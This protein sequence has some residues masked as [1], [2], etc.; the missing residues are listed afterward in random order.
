M[1][2]VVCAVLFF[3]CLARDDLWRLFW[4]VIL[5]GVVELSVGLVWFVG[6]CSFRSVVVACFGMSAFDQESAAL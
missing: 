3:V 1:I 6:Y 4:V 5:G 2:C